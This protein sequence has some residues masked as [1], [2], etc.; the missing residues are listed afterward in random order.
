MENTNQTINQKH[1]ST[2]I[3]LKQLASSIVKATLKSLRPLLKN[4]WLFAAIS[5]AILIVQVSLFVN[6]TFGIYINAIVFALLVRLAIWQ[7]KARQLAISVA[8]L[9]VATMISLSLP[10]TTL[11]ARSVVFYDAILILGLIYRFM[12]TLNQPLKSTQLT[13]RGYLVVLPAMVVLGQLLGALGYFMLRHQYTFGH[14][15]LPL[16]ATTAVVFAIGEEVVFRGLIQQRAAKVLHPI[17]AAG[18]ATVLYTAFSFGHNGSYLAP[19]FGL[20][21]GAILATIYYKKQ[22]LV[23]T[24]CVNTVSKLVYVGLMASFIFH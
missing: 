20:L 17:M 4:S 16:V 8:I 12:F 11:F 3:T 21:M 10:Q 9:P 18:L 22:N 5:L 13:R 23:L 1:S 15:S 6:P 24:I 7:D 14:T 2:D 19:V